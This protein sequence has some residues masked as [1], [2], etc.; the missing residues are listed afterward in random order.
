MLLQG[1]PSSSYDW[2]HVFE[3]LPGRRLVTFDFLGFGLSDKPRD[4]RYSL[5]GQADL[6]QAIAAHRSPGST[7]RA[8]SRP[9]WAHRSRP[10]CW[11]ATS[12]ALF[13]STDAVF[14]ASLVL[15]Q[16]SLLL[17]QK[18]LRSRLGPMFARLTNER[19]IQALVR[20]HVRSRHP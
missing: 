10:S 3:L 1:Y 2:R 14:N 4:H 17:G 19:S 8:S 9:T 13:D 5:L 16:A 6:V 12:R 15:E 18:L 7:R 20:R 11:H